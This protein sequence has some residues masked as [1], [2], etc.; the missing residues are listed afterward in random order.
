MEQE[1]VFSASYDIEG[2]LR[3]VWMTEQSTQY[4][5][6]ECFSIGENN[7]EYRIFKVG[8]SCDWGLSIDGD[9]LGMNF[10]GQG[11]AEMVAA[12]IEENRCK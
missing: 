2:R 11:A 1:G 6:T 12:T 10:K 9:A 4:G 8:G 5:P 7:S 3:M